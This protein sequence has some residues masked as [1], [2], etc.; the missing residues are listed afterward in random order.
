M[1]VYYAVIF[2]GTLHCGAFQTVP[3]ELNISHII[4]IELICFI[5][6]KLETDKEEHCCLQWPYFL[7]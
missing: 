4:L 1:M 2:I 7:Y 5:L 6:D 3:I